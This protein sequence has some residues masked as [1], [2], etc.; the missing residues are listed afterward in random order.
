[1][2]WQNKKRIYIAEK[3]ATCGVI[4]NDTTEKRLQVKMHQN[5]EEFHEKSISSAEYIFLCVSTV[6]ES[7]F[8]RLSSSSFFNSS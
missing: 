1:M 6:L 4:D 7:F 2:K 5:G 8:F 3:V